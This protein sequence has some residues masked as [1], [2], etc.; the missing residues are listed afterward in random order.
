M[1]CTNESNRL[2]LLI[3]DASAAATAGSS[4][5]SI[6]LLPIEVRKSYLSRMLSFA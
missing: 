6:S 5:E 4:S 1:S 2:L 3:A